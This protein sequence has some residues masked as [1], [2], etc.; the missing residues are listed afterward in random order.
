MEANFKDS[1][2][3][4]LV[5]VS[6]T[7]KRT[8]TLDGIDKCGS[9]LIQE[10][11]TFVSE[12]K[13]LRTISFIGHSMGGLIARYA[14]GHAYN[15]EDKTVFCLEPLHF[16]TICSPHF[17]CNDRYMTDIKK[18]DSVTPC[19]RWMGAIPV[20][21]KVPAFLFEVF[22]SFFVN[23][24]LRKTGDQLFLRD[25][26]PIIVQMA[27]DGAT[28]VQFRDPSFLDPTGDKKAGKPGNKTL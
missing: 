17:G 4:V 10:V 21:G 11:K 20:V 19:L 22:E 16:I 9:R 2:D 26:N 28:E 7:N 25:K 12:H 8:K 13:S 5:Y 15:Q 6:K 3:N 24:V 23:L 27:T 1:A 18:E 14:V